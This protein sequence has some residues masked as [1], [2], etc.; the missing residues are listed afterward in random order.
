MR[1]YD[2]IMAMARSG[3]PLS[4]RKEKKV[5]LLMEAIFKNPATSNAWVLGDGGHRVFWLTLFVNNIIPLRWK[6]NRFSLF[7]Y[8]SRGFGK[9]SRMS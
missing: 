7:L 9:I 5:L 4:Q 8:V 3:E 6:H 1:R 2:D